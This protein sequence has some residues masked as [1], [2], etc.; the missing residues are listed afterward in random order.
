[1]KKVLYT[2]FII[3][4]CVL[5]MLSMIY[6]FSKDEPLFF[7]KSVKV[8]GLEQLKDGDVLSRIAPFL[9][10]SIFAADVSRIRESIA[11]HP[12]VRE[13]SVRRIYPFSIVIDV[14][15]KVPS[16]LWVD[17]EGKVHVLDEQGVPYRGPR[18][19]VKWRACSS[20]IQ[21]TRSLQRVFTGTHRSG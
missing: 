1:M 8:T 16:A 11:A 3:P 4:L 2:L 20:S 21:K 5:S 18:G 17:G 9:K 7:L 13:A 14:K 12:F 10:E 15:E 6:L 19:K